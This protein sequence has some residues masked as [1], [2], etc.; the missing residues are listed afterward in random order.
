MSKPKYQ[1]ANREALLAQEVDFSTYELP[2]LNLAERDRVYE[3][4]TEAEQRLATADGSAR[5]Y[6]QGSATV[7]NELLVL[8]GV[9]SVL[10][11]AEHATTHHR[12]Q[13]DRNKERRRRM[14][15]DYGVAGL[16]WAVCEDTGSSLILPTG[17]QLGDADSDFKHPLK[18]IIQ[19]F[20]ASPSMRAH[21]SI[22]DM[23]IGRVSTIQDTR[24]YNVLI[25]IGRSA[26]TETKDFAK[27]AVDI[28]GKY[29]LRAGVNESVVLF[30][31]HSA[32]P[33]RSKDGSV[34]TVRYNAHGPGKMREFSQQF[35]KELGKP[36]IAAEID[37]SSS[38]RLLPKEVKNN[39]GEVSQRT[40]TYLAYLFLRDCAALID[41]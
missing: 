29:G 25:G 11:T 6:D 41:A 24:S 16:S 23:N 17:R 22:Q 37:F 15:A 31:P 33:K 27:A 38:L 35:C 36:L 30:E 3:R 2:E 18:N 34:A 26:T 9:S 39:P 19:P 10:L 7:D 21:L 4:I 32:Q 20:L 40:G 8:H 28:A 14:R 5:G 1:P 13:K 12:I